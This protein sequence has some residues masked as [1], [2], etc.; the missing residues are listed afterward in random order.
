RY[1]EKLDQ[2]AKEYIGFAVDG[3]KRMQLLINALLDYSRVQNRPNP[4]EWIDMDHVFDKAVIDV[5]LRIKETGAKI[6]RGSLPKIKGDAVQMAQLLE[7][8][9]MNAMKFRKDK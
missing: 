1:R 3:A 8:L 2:D 6:T 7:N 4:F 5:E 9:F